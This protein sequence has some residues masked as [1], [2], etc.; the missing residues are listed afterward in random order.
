[1][2]SKDLERLID[3]FE[4]STLLELK[5]TQGNTKVHLGRRQQAPASTTETPLK[6]AATV[7]VPAPAAPLDEHLI[8]AP[9]AGIV[10]LR[11]SPTKPDFT[12]VGSQV[13]EG[14]T[15]AVIEA[16][17]L[18]NPLEAEF[19][20]EIVEILVADGEDVERGTPIYRA[21]KVNHV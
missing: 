13:S 14:D 6:P 15:L 8:A 4:R 20:C 11:P 19:A 17:K 7:V 10:Y 5:Y 3:S 21:R 18:F 12:S 1:M 2:H 16:M 9:M